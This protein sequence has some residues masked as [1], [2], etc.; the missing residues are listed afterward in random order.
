MYWL[1]AYMGQPSRNLWTS[2]P[3]SANVA[4]GAMG[5][6][7]NQIFAHSLTTTLGYL[8]T[9]Y[10]TPRADGTPNDATGHPFPWLQW[11]N[12]PFRIQLGIDAGSIQQVFPFVIRLHV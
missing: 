1:L 7:N 5:N 9:T 8:N 4:A 2:E 3:V 10:G 6:D 12:R 11:N